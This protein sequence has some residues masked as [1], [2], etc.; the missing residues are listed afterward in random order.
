MIRV[1]GGIKVGLGFTMQGD[2]QLADILEHFQGNDPVVKELV[3]LC[4]CNKLVP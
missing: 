4:G 2:V 3:S 1:I